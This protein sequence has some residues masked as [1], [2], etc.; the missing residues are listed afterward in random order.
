MSCPHEV[1]EL[2]PVSDWGAMPTWHCGLCRDVV[3]DCDHARQQPTPTGWRCTTC[4]RSL[5]GAPP[6]P[7]SRR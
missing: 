2:A 7:A 6:E 1:L 3:R 4:R 5:L